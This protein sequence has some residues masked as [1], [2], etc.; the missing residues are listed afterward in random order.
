MAYKLPSGIYR[1]SRSNP[2][3]GTS[4]IVIVDGDDM[5][6]AIG[7]F[8][9]NDDDDVWEQS[10]PTPANLISNVDANNGAAIISGNNYS[11][12]VGSP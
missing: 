6:T 2:T 11:Y 9:W 10:P 12:T 3:D 8:E 5:S 1:F 4:M 7:D